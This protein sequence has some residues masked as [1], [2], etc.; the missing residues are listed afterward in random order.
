MR[1]AVKMGVIIVYIEHHAITA[2]PTLYDALA[3]TSAYILIYYV[4]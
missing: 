2:T 1:K 3:F 4:F